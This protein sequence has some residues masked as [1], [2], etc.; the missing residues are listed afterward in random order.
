MSLL[1]CNKKV[2]FDYLYVRKVSLV[3]LVHR[4]LPVVQLTR[5]TRPSKNMC[6]KPTF[7]TVQT[8]TQREL[9][10]PYAKIINLNVTVLIRFYS[11]LKVH[12]VKYVFRKC[13]TELHCLLENRTSG[14]KFV[15]SLCSVHEMAVNK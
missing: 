7:Q 13:F 2:V 3:P 15:P 9:L 1:L 5:D 10:Y 11:K 14:N 4:V 8:L 6:I 12:Q